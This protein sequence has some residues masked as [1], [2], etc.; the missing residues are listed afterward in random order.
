MKAEEFFQI[1]NFEYHDGNVSNVIFDADD[2]ILTVIRCP[3]TLKSKED[4]D[5]LFQRLKFK[6]VSDIYLW[7]DDKIY[8]SSTL[9]ED[10]WKTASQKDVEDIFANGVHSWI[11]DAFYNNGMV[12]YDYLLRFKCADIEIL[13]SR[14]NPEYLKA[15][16][17]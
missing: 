9:W 7:N 5:S 2:M 15:P 8:T 11:D 4:E 16:V 17:D 12:V 3:I 1:Y 6:N 10:M 14:T 13:E